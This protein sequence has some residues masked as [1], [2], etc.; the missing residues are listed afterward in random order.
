M[1]AYS[2]KSCLKPFQLLKEEMSG[3]KTQKPKVRD[4]SVSP[5][6]GLY[7]MGDSQAI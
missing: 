2:Q 1:S 6:G 5:T 7:R 4:G 3:I